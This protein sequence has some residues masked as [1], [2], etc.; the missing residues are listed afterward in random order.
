[1]SN[2]IRTTFVLIGPHAGKTITLGKLTPFPFVDGKLTITATVEEMGLYANFLASNWQA[3]PEG[4][5]AVEEFFNGKREVHPDPESDGQPPLPGE[6]QPNGE[7]S[8]AGGGEAEPGAGAAEGEAGPAGSVSAGDGH[9]PELNTRL[10]RAIESLDPGND[11]HWTQ[12]GKPA[13]AMVER[14]YGAADITRADV[15]AAAPGYN[16]EVAQAK[17]EGDE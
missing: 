13:M 6:V 11:N 9:P 1:M 3:Y 12:D 5:E 16:R 8:A 7:A 4:H 2:V 17:A 14:L 15:S 10:L